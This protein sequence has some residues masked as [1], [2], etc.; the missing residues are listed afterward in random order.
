MHHHF[1]NH[2]HHRA[3]RISDIGGGN[4]F[5]H[6]GHSHEGLY[7]LVNYSHYK[8]SSQSPYVIYISVE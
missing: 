6:S 4:G 1:H 8:S 7:Q 2:N 5:G 3:R